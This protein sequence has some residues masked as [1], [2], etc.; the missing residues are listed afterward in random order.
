MTCQTNLTLDLTGDPLNADDRIVW[1]ESAGN[2]ATITYSNFNGGFGQA[3]SFLI[4]ES[5][6]YNFGTGRGFVVSDNG[7]QVV[8]ENVT[9]IFPE[10]QLIRGRISFATATINELIGNEGT[11]NELIATSSAT[12]SANTTLGLGSAI[13]VLP[14]S[15]T[16]TVNFSA[17]FNFQVG[18]Q[19]YSSPFGFIQ[20]TN[21]VGAFLAGETVSSCCGTFRIVNVL[22]PN[23]LLI[24]QLTENVITG[25]PLTGD[26]SGATGTISV[27]GPH[28]PSIS[29]S[30]TISNLDVFE[31]MQ[32]D[33]LSGTFNV[34]DMIFGSLSAGSIGT[35]NGFSSTVSSET[36]PHR[37]LYTRRDAIARITQD[38]TELD[39]PGCDG[40]L[41]TVEMYVYPVPLAPVEADDPQ[42]D[43]NILACSGDLQGTDVL[44]SPV[45]SNPDVEYTWYEDMA[46]SMP[47]GTDNITYGDLTSAIG[48][49]TTNVTSMPVTTNVWITQTTNKKNA[50]TG[51]FQG[52]EGPATQVDITV[53]PNPNEPT[54]TAEDGSMSAL[55]ERTTGIGNPDVQITLCEGELE[56]SVAAM[57]PYRF[58]AEGP[59]GVT[60]I[61]WFDSDVNGDHFDA[62]RL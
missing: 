6:E 43:I 8:L 35:V 51:T 31:V 57:L 5:V 62:N 40:D 53:Y 4:G 42:F 3:P 15:I 28:Q 26:I 30:G 36:V 20:Y 18:E 56:A 11:G 16:G 10:G 37:F 58:T 12:V 41:T 50:L 9:G 22:G 32:I 44:F 55:S 54:F 29:G 38:G 7:S 61:D 13:S 14:A 60:T 52:C 25:D 59:V 49:S 33:D 21:G 23:Q 19:A 48:F 1:F 45:G 39:F 27:V 17:V 24:D 46:L 47:M 2:T 34:G